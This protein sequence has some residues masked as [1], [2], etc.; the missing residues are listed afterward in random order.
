MRNFNDAPIERPADEPT[1]SQVAAPADVPMDADEGTDGPQMVEA[2]APSSVRRARAEFALHGNGWGYR[3]GAGA[4]VDL[5]EEV[6]PGERIGDHIPS[7][8]LEALTEE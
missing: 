3:R 5:D 7:H 8:L 4:F 1:E 6:A 2:I